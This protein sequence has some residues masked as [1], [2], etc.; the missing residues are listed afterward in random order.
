MVFMLWMYLYMYRCVVKN[1]QELVGGDADLNELEMLRIRANIEFQNRLGR[2]KGL[3]RSNRNYPDTWGKMTY[4]NFTFQLHKPGDA[5]L[6]LG[7]TDVVWSVLGWTKGHQQKY[8]LP[9]VW[10]KDGSV[11]PRFQPKDSKTKVYLYFLYF[12][13]PHSSNSELHRWT[14]TSE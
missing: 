4:W 10:I 3:L 1:V 6:E 2:T 14:C 9:I 11:R 8:Y 7:Q 13:I 5:R 12:S